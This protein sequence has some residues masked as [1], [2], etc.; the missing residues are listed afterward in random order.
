MTSA[1][2]APTKLTLQA[3]VVSPARLDGRPEVLAGDLHEAQMPGDH[4][5]PEE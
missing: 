2:T 3:G 4:P 1:A 5:L